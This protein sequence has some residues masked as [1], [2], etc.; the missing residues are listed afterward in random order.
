VLYR[1][2]ISS[3]RWPLAVVGVVL[4]GL[5]L[6]D[7]AHRRHLEADAYEA[8]IGPC[9]QAGASEADCVKRIEASSRRCF[10]ANYTSG[11]KYHSESFNRGGYQACVLG[12][13]ESWDRADL[14]ARAAARVQQ[15]QE[16][17]EAP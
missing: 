12:G 11:S 15:A 3:S 8:A 4:V 5:L 9:V 6:W 13:Y 16:R 2:R 7:N 10:R 17:R 14:D 1:P